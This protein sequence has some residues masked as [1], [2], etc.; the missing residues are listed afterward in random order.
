MT[1]IPVEPPANVRNTL[2]VASL[3]TPYCMFYVV[4][5]LLAVVGQSLKPVILL[6]QQLPKFLLFRDLRSEAQQCWIRLHSSSSIVGA[7]YAHYTSSPKS[8][9]GLHPSHDALQVRF[10]YNSIRS[11]CMQQIHTF[12]HK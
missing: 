9:V 11:L 12:S 1:F 5:W 7:M 4:A 8:Y 2:H 3:C 6:S 10:P